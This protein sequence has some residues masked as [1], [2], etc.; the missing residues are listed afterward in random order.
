MPSERFHRLS[1]E[2]QNLIWKASMKEFIAVPYEK[3]SINKIIRD[4]GISRGS[5]YTY[6]EDKRDVLSFLLEDTT[7][8]WREFCLEE[9]DKTYGDVFSLMESM[10]DH[11]LRFC[12][13]NDMFRLHK[14]LIMYPD[15]VLMECRADDGELERLVGEEFFRRIDRSKLRDNSTG[16]VLLL[17]KL[18]FVA[19]TAG[20]G[21]FH[22]HPD[23]EEIIKREY[24]KALSIL[25]YGARKD[26]QQDQAKE[27]ADE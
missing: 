24:K 3:V 16:G 25:K 20:I 27:Q 22:K 26:S 19:M 7:R 14:N 2:K 23:H 18:C 11:A 6:F 5:F 8:K 4:A 10:M 15:D 12:K 1:K 9:L 17:V 13:N 21:E